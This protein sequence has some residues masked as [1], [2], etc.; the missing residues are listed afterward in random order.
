MNTVHITWQQGGDSNNQTY[1][2]CTDTE[3]EIC[4]AC[5]TLA[6]MPELVQ[7]GITLELNTIVLNRFIGH[8]S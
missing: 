8:K 6:P 7:W 2:C 3:T 5:A 4:Q 1:I